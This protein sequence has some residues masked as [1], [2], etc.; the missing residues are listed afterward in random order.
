M[1]RLS[2]LYS[3]LLRS[4][5]DLFTHSILRFAWRLFD[6]LG[7]GLDMVIS[8]GSEGILELLKISVMRSIKIKLRDIL[9]E[10]GQLLLQESEVC[11]VCFNVDE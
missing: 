1:P 7:A 3:P 8:W 2:H 11:L 4:R 5:H 9:E 6:R 10:V